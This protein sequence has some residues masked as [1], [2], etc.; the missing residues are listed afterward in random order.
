[1]LWR[2][3]VLWHVTT[4][5]DGL[6]LE[7]ERQL[8]VSLLQETYGRWAWRWRA[9]VA[10]RLA[11]RLYGAG[12]LEP[13]ARDSADGNSSETSLPDWA[14]ADLLAAAARIFAKAERDGVRL[15]RLALAAG[16]REQGFAIANARIA[17]LA[18]LAASA[19]CLVITSNGRGD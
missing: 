4:Y 7:Y 6:R 15:T 14:D 5:R 13:E 2:R 12:N 8:R 10:E 19:P 17:E 11:L 16:L 9:P 18:A 1:M 3:M